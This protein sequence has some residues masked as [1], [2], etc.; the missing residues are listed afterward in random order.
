MM[1]AASYIRQKCPLCGKEKD[2]RILFVFSGLDVVKCRS[3]GM[4]YVRN[5]RFDTSM[6]PEDA[7]INRKP[8]FRHLQIVNL[9]KNYFRNYNNPLN[10][11]EIG[12]G[13]GYLARILMSQ[14]LNINYTGFELGKHRADFCVENGINVINDVVCS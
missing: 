3:C 14:N 4:M 13:Y 6:L 1:E 10:I 9:I 8:H 11:A 12:C 5:P 7:D 2:A